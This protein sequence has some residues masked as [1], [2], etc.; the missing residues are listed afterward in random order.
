MGPRSLEFA[1]NGGGA[2][3]TD[4]AGTGGSRGLVFDSPGGG[5]IQYLSATYEP[6]VWTDFHGKLS[7][8][9]RVNALSSAI[10]VSPLNA[11]TDEISVR[12]PATQERLF[13]R[14][15]VSTP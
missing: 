11:E 8:W 1:G 14:L 13:L 9:S 5:A 6:A 7:T 2:L 12:V 15:D 3:L 4:G 10:Q